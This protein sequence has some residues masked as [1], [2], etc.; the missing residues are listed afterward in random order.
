M[1]NYWNSYDNLTVKISFEKDII[2]KIIDLEKFKLDLFYSDVIDKIKKNQ[3]F[4]WIKTDGKWLSR[5][6]SLASNS[7]HW[8]FWLSGYWKSNL[9]KL[10][11]NSLIEKNEDNYKFLL[12]DI[13]RWLEKLNRLNSIIWFWWTP[14]EIN[15]YLDLVIDHMQKVSQIFQKNWV[16]SFE[17]FYRK[18]LK[19]SQVFRLMVIFEEFWAVSWEA[20]KI[21]LKGINSK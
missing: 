16:S 12:L 6:I 1:S 8:V 21:T 5:A 11:I 7:H 19:H 9:V 15:N 4:Y 2:I 10:L 13:S 17:W 18:K 20:E 3:F 14:E